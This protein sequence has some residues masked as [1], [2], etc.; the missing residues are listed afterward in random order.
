MRSGVTVSAKK[1]AAKYCAKVDQLPSGR[2]RCSK[3]KGT[4]AAMIAIA[5]RRM[6]FHHLF[7]SA[8]QKN[9]SSIK[10]PIA[11]ARVMAEILNMD[12][13]IV[14]GIK[15]NGSVRRAKAKNTHSL[16]L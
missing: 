12:S 5:S 14:R 13:V 16:F 11:A 3:R 9:F 6:R 2:K 10:S 15:R 7:A 4:A 1:I 8:K